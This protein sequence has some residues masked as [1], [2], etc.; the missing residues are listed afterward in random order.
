MLGHQWVNVS[1]STATLRE[2]DLIPAFE[3]VLDEA[4]VGYDRPASVDKL[5]AG[6]T[7]TETERDEVGWYLNEVLFDQLNDI[8]PEGTYFGS[9][10]GDG[11]DFGFWTIEEG[12]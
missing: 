3:E 8:A 1:V 9:H 5:L 2:E 11:A 6:E 12:Y 4:E 10:P 7:L